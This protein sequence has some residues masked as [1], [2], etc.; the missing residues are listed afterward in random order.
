MR[1]HTEG[2]TDT[3]RGSAQEDDR[4]RIIPYCT[5][6]SK[7]RQYC[8]WPF[9]RTLY[10]LS[11]PRP[12]PFMSQNS[13]LLL[14]LVRCCFFFFFSLVLSDNYISPSCAISHCCRA[15]VVKYLGK[16]MT[17]L[18]SE[19]LYIYIYI[20]IYIYLPPPAFCVA[21]GN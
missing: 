20:Y 17:V 4:G 9:C 16:Q 19:I 5:G 6:D 10:Q 8:T 21:L 14:L 11:Y 2:C 12:A 18:S 1:L 13:V 3:V 15:Q 7:P